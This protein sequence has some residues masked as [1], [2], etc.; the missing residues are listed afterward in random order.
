MSGVSAS[1]IKENHNL[2]IGEHFT[3]WVEWGLKYEPVGDAKDYVGVTYPPCKVGS[4]YISDFIGK[5]VTPEGKPAQFE[6]YDMRVLEVT[7]I[8]SFEVKE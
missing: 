5:K 7:H 3:I 2:T 4:Y 8:L 6:I 1:F